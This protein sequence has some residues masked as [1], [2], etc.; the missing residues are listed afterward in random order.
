MEQDSLVDKFIFSHIP[1]FYRSGKVDRHIVHICETER[2][3]AVVE[4]QHGCPKVERV[5][6]HEHFPRLWIIL[7]YGNNGD[8]YVIPKRATFHCAPAS[9][10][11]QQ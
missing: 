8:P 3:T 1:T 6:R 9:A 11:R 7:F 10:G 5:L 2:Q 4:H